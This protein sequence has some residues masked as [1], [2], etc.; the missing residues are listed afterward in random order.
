MSLKHVITG[1]FVLKGMLAAAF[2]LS[3]GQA[4]A[5]SGR[6]DYD[7]DNDGLIEINDL[8]DLYEIRD[9]LDG[10]KLYN[11]SSGCP[12]SGCN[13][14]ELTTDLDFD[15]SGDG[16]ITNKDS[17]WNSGSGWEPIGSQAS[18]FTATF[19]GNGYTIKNLFINRGSTNAVG[20]FASIN[21]ATLRNIHVTGS[22]TGNYFTGAL[23]GFSQVDSTLS[24]CS[25]SG[26]VSGSSLVGGLAGVAWLSSADSCSVDA[27]VT[28]SGSA[29]G[30]FGQW[31]Y[32]GGTLDSGVF[33]G[34]VSGGSSNL[35]GLVGWSTSVT[36]SDSYV[37]ATITTTGDN[38]G[39]L[40]GYLASSSGSQIDRTFARGSVSGGNHSGGLIGYVAD[41]LTLRDSYAGNSV[42]GGQYVGGLMG[43]LYADATMQ[44]LYAR[45]SV[46]GSSDS[47]GLVGYTDSLISVTRIYWDTETTGQSSSAGDYGS[48]LTS[49]ELKC[50]TSPGDGTCGTSVYSGWSTGRWDFGSSSQ[51][52]VSIIGGLTFRDTDGDGEYDP[53]DS[54]IDGDDVENDSDAFPYDDTESADNDGDGIGDNAD[55]DDDNDGVEDA[56]DAF[57]FD[58]TE[59]SDH[60]GDGTGDNADTDDDNDGVEDALDAFP[61]DE[62]ESA[63]NDGDGTGDNADTDDDN[64]GVE[65]ALDAFPFDETENADNDSDGTGDNADT[66]DDNDGV[67][68]TSDAFPFDET[69]SADADGDGTGDNADTDDDNDGVEDALD[70]FPYNPTESVDSDGDGIGDNADSDDDNDGV[71]DTSDAFPYDDSET[72]DNDGD[73]I[74]DNADTDDDNDGVEDALDAFPFD[75]TESA[76]ND[77]DGTG[78]NAD[79]DDDNDGVEDTSDV[80]PYDATESSDHDGDGTG[81]NADTDDDN[82][83]VEDALDAFP[84]DETESAD[85]DS[86]GTGDNA[87]TDDDN[88]GVEDASDAFPYDA[89]ET[90]DND[91]DGTGDNADSDDDNDG[92]EDASD[93][94]PYDETETSDSDS[95]GTGD[96][97]DVDVDGDGLIEIGSLE[98]LDN[99]RNNLTGS[100]YNDGSSDNLLGCGDG[101]TVT[102]CRGYELTSSL[103]F[104]TNTDGVIDAG[105]SYWNDGAGW[106]PI[107]TADD[108]YSA[109]FDGNGHTIANLYI[110]RAETNGVGLFGAAEN[111]DIR[112]I[113]LTGERMSITGGQGVGGLIGSG[114]QVAVTASYATGSVSGEQYVG[115]IFGSSE[116][117]GITAS[118]FTGDV[119]ST[120]SAGGLA[121]RA[122]DYAT[123]TGSFVTGSVTSDGN[124]GGLVGD[125]ANLTITANYVIALVSGGTSGALVADDNSGSANSYIA[126][127]WADV[128]DTE[129]GFSRAI[130]KCPV[131]ADDTA[132]SEDASTLYSGWADLEDGSGNDY[133]DFGGDTQLPGLLLNGVVYRDTD[134]DG[135][136]DGDD[137]YPADFDNDGVDDSVD[138]FPEDA[139]ETADA[140]E[141]GVGDNTD[142]FPN[143]PEETTDSDNDGV[144]DNS[145]AFPQDPNESVDTDNDGTGDNSDTTPSGDDADSDNDGMSDSFEVEYGLDINDPSDA[146]GDLDGDG[147]SN[148]DEYLADTRVDQDDVP[149]VLSVPGDI[150]VVSS[151][152]TTSVDIGSATAEDAKDGS[153]VATADD[154]G[155]FV[156]GRHTIT[157]RASD[158]AGNSVTAEQ[159]VDVIPLVSIAAAQT[160]EEGS[161]GVIEF[162]LNGAPVEYP[163]TVAFVI[164][165]SADSSDHD[166]VSG[167]LEIDAGLTGTM[168]FSTVADTS[169]EGEENIVVTLGH[170]S[171]AALGSS[172]EQTITLTEDNVAPAVSIELVQ[173]NYSVATVF[174]DGGMATVIAGVEDPNPSDSHRYTWSS[175]NL[176]PTNGYNSESFTF[177]PSGLSGLFT[178][179]LSVTDTA[180]A[181]ASTTLLFSIQEAMPQ[182]SDSADSDGDGLSDAEEGFGD[183]DGDRVPDYLDANSTANL[184]PTDGLGSLMEGDSGT[185]L[186]LGNSAYVAGYGIALIS[187]DDIDGLY[188][189][190]LADTS[191]YQFLHGI[192]DFEI[193]GVA[194]G[195]STRVVLPQTSALLADA[196][197]LKYQQG[198]GWVAFTEDTENA[199]A[200]AP[201]ALGVCPAP[202]SEEY[203]PGLSEGHYCVQLTIED[204]GP[205]D[206]DGTANGIVVDPGAVGTLN[207]VAPTVTVSALPLSTAS[208]TAGDGEKVVLAF[209]LESDSSDA[210]VSVLS[211]QTSGDLEEGADVSSVKLYLDSNS[212][213]QAE[214]DELLVSGSYTR[215]DEALTFNL[216]E[217]IQLQSGE[218]RFLLTYQF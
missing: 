86:D 201:G 21:G 109:D 125:S 173:G 168:A 92:V 153:L 77:S 1:K 123:I 111:A 131:L 138:A 202:G 205:N 48:G 198:I 57:P 217:A 100:A 63:D 70:A 218:R 174:A 181:S 43:G 193:R 2:L 36:L 101:D 47:G 192:F 141:D 8:A 54:D 90:A 142:E 176:A 27:T 24:D 161:T 110:D 200:S 208:F 194:A 12:A 177:D 209:T 45:G 61:F 97:T 216:P 166:L 118:F 83:G 58:E 15:T 106:E 65:D 29:G 151:G 199:I 40:I 172:I 190:G 95:D 81:D 195:A 34:S 133:W 3:L 22:V 79:T 98:E 75:E 66:D 82:D 107:G 156:P 42:S 183:G 148:L 126:N 163:V 159:I 171:N 149:P 122:Y 23:F 120:D 30:L 189:E 52:P 73:G 28:S 53:Y 105:D 67:D 119:F 135:S 164:S 64:D 113:G 143:D 19:D 4:Q 169:F 132:C 191:N 175:D 72:S 96:N 167:A 214:A 26:S 62:T 68:D 91:G 51:Y 212:N 196:Q 203:E 116:S 207:T 144:G 16:S 103:D 14:F 13:G 25:F 99:I 74:G 7:L 145:D 210:E 160:L 188:A 112:N 93:A 128:T 206:A 94:F 197:Y 130:L 152:A 186:V 124:A 55:T 136:L 50:P 178:V 41:A 20:L 38:A 108:R 158:A 127:Y 211:F 9:H 150:E 102:A 165:G 84:F 187:L 180:G 162:S 89:S 60:D 35:G 213:G 137:A 10:T 157:W 18:P 76:D 146:E 88:D 71:E 117:G 129:S 5:E 185:T 182:L 49:S 154:Y 170:A 147:V 85:N 104:D 56:S 140:D 184:L 155:P 39:A 134:G 17:Y 32:A 215:D 44:R 59:S 115:G 6:S 80:F 33:T 179:A 87:D 31:N 78:D 69:E 11:S 46:S 121:G 139:S 204:G 114:S 37:D